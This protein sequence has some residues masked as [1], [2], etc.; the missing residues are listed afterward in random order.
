MIF[1]YTTG[2]FFQG[3]YTKNAAHPDRTCKRSMAGRQFLHHR[4]LQHVVACPVAE[5]ATRWKA[6]E[7]DNTRQAELIIVMNWYQ[8]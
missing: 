4:V 8:N 3:Y 1:P 7:A 6:K 5:T 2:I